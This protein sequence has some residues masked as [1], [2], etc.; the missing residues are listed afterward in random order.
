MFLYVTNKALDL[1]FWLLRDRASP[2]DSTNL[3]LFWSECVR[4]HVAVLM[5]TSGQL[6]HVVKVLK[7]STVTLTLAK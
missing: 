2:F 4:N 1:E 3:P 6:C 7:T 5:P